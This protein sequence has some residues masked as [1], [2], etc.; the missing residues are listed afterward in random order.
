MSSGQE[1]QEFCS[2]HEPCGSPDNEVLQLTAC[3]VRCRLAPAR[4]VIPKEGSR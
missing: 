1:P 3:F 2:V 4:Y